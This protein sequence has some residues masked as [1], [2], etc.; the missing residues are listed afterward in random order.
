VKDLFVYV[1]ELFVLWE[2]VYFK[3]LMGLCEEKVCFLV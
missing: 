3:L 2:L 1:D